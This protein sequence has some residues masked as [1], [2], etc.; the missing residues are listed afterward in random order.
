MKGASAI[1]QSLK[2]WMTRRREPATDD[3]ETPESEVVRACGRPIPMDGN[4]FDARR[5]FSA[6]PDRWPLGPGHENF[7]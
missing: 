4:E 3:I 2:D 1:V 6:Q 5:E 7:S